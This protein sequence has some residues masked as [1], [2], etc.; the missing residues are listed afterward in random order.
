MSSL[1]NYINSWW[2]GP[3][4]NKEEINTKLGEDTKKNVSDIICLITVNDLKNVKLKPVKDIIPSPARNMPPINKF[5]LNMLNKAQ[6]EAILS[7]KLRPV[8]PFHI[9]KYESRNPV[10]RELLQKVER[11]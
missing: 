5:H 4:Q 10:L 6:L 11:C 2:Y 3:E 8:P 1:V 9:K 7:V